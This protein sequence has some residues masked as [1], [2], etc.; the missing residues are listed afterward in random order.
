VGFGW[1]GYSSAAAYALQNKVNYDQ[2]LSWID[3]AIAINPGFPP[4]V[5]KA[6][7]LNEMGKTAEADKVMQDAIA[8]S[9]ENDLNNY[10]YQLL[11]QGQQDKAINIFITNT[12]R[13]P[14]SANVWDSLGEGYAIKGDK[15]NAIS[16]FRKS[17]SMNPPAN[18]K[19][20]SEKY[21]KQLGAL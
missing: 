16:S 1:Q 14:E 10:G 12:K 2:A 5:I 20:N 3:Q 8:A 11:N 18:V 9:S 6:G 15:Q 4:Q 17:L 13:H 7:L 21:L 19:A